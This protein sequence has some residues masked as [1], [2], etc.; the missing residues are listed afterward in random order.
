MAE[1]PGNAAVLEP[2]PAPVEGQPRRVVDRSYWAEVWRQFRKNKP[3]MVG[4]GLVVVLLVLALSSSYLANDR[5]LLL[6]RVQKLPG[7]DRPVLTLTS[8]A[9]SSCDWTEQIAQVLLLG[10]AL[11]WGWRRLRPLPAGMVR[12]PALTRGTLLLAVVL[13]ALCVFIYRTKPRLDTT[14][15]ARVLKKLRPEA[16]EWALS[17]PLPYSPYGV[18]LDAIY[19]PPSAAHRLG[20]DN[21]GRD[22]LTRILHGTKISLSVGL[23]AVSIELVI[24]ILLGALAGY[25]GK[26]CD[27]VIM[28]IIEVFMCFPTFFLLI[29]IVAFLP[30]NIFVIMAVIGIT[31]WPTIARLIRGEFLKVRKMDYVAAAQA[32]GVPHLRVMLRHILPNAISPALVAASFGIAGAILAESSLTFLGFGVD[33]STPSWGEALHEAWENYRN[34]WL[35]VFPG[36][37]IFVTVT[38][39]NLVGEGLRDAIDP[40]LKT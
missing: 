10:V 18:D 37:A 29:T 2:A 39:Y 5:P 14:D 33:P 34:W 13:A 31:G 22:L 35:A 40:R 21:V 20:T 32:L 38:A 17:A 7:A 26:G 12:R 1:T 6:R 36:A 28:R 15:Y 16:G 24:G 4:L 25:F 9:W 3:A 19:R 11:R 27:L 30:R 8:P 23:V